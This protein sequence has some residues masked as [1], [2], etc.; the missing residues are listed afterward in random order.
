MVPLATAVALSL[1][2]ASARH[3]AALALE[4]MTPGPA[5]PGPEV[6]CPDVGPA[7]AVPE[8]REGCVASVGPPLSALLRAIGIEPAEARVRARELAAAAR[9]ALER[10]SA[11]GLT[12]VAHGDRA[13]PPRLAALPDPPFVLWVRGRT[14]VLCRPAVAIVGT[15][16]ASPASQ[17]LARSLARDLASQGLV[18]VSGLARGIDAAAH[19]GAL[20]ASAGGAGSTVAVVGCGADIVY[21][22]EHAALHERIGRDGAVASEFPPGTP[23][24]RFHF[25]IRNRLVSGL[26]LGVVVVE[27]PERS[28]ALITAACALDQGREVMVVPGPARSERFRGSHALIRDGAAL[29]EEAADVLAVLGWRCG[30]GN[31][32]VRTLGTGTDAAAATAGRGL[33]PGAPRT[34]YP[35]ADAGTTGAGAGPTG[36]HGGHPA[37]AP[38]DTAAEA[39]LRSWRPGV[40][41]DLDEL[42]EVMGMGAPAALARLA[43]WELCGLVSR[44]AA[45]R[46]VRLPG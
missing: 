18:V 3:A 36:G 28:G 5:R 15:R 19:E 21:P 46:F 9:A 14:D 42:I 24:R 2:P 6:E 11:R 32:A 33:P 45:G 37:D 16:R 41:R 7:P 40:E 25:P 31:A 38:G 22:R 26:A 1:L 8:G 35:L 30:A 43:E 13:Y 10:G 23:A 44:T 27:A 12:P 20:E 34:S 17:T 4:R 39:A 29:V